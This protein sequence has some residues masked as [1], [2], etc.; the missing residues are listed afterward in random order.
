MNNMKRD[1]NRQLGKGAG[2]AVAAEIEK[3][4]NSLSPKQDGNKVV[5]DLTIDGTTVANALNSAGGNPGGGNPGGNNPGGGG[6][7]GTVDAAT[8]LN[9]FKQIVLAIHSH[10][11]QNGGNLSLSINDPQTNRPLLSWRVAI[12]PY[13]GQETLYK[14]IRLNEAWDSAHN[15][16]FWDKMPKL[17]ESPGLP[18]ATGL[19]A[20]QVFTGPITPF[21]E[22][23]A[24]A[25]FPATFSDGASNTILIAEAS[26]PVNWLK[27]EDMR[28][29][30]LNNLRFL[31]ANRTGR[32][33]VVGMADGAVK[34]LKQQINNATL[35]ALITPSGNEVLGSDW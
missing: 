19:T 4:M 26:R 15:R 21:P 13:L 9:N 7:R 31:L 6:I 23:G 34:N 27:P 12:L 24:L 14:S 33:T 1:L 35:R 2:D 25:R 5:V 16:Q 10:V 3:A 22:A 30:D 8:I 32:G 20:V 11:E 17:Y 18:P 29:I 28:V